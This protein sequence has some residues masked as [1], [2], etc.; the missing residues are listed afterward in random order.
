[1]LFVAAVLYALCV[2]VISRLPKAE[3]GNTLL[4]GGPLFP[5][6]AFGTGSSFRHLIAIAWGMIA[7]GAMFF[8]TNSPPHVRE[9][10]QTIMSVSFLGVLALGML[11]IPTSVHRAFARKEGRAQHNDDDSGPRGSS[12]LLVCGPEDVLIRLQSDPQLTLALESVAMP[13]FRV[14]PPDAGPLIDRHQTEVVTIGWDQ[15]LT[16]AIFGAYQQAIDESMAQASKCLEYRSALDISEAGVEALRV[17]IEKLTA[18]KRDLASQLTG[19]RRRNRGNSSVDFS[20]MSVEALTAERETVLKTVRTIDDIMRQK[21][22][23]AAAPTQQT[24][25]LGTLSASQRE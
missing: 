6:V 15:M 10:V 9:V 8:S 2:F 12:Q 21:A 18:E 5:H 16:D 25:P 7:A 22:A 13:C 24:L 23:S 3:G 4:F 17:S 11:F 14:S 19:L 20:L 1:M